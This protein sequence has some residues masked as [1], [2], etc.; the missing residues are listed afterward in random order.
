MNRLWSDSAVIV[1]L[2]CVLLTI[3][4]YSRRY[5]RSVADFLAARRLGGRYLLAVASGFGGGVSLVAMWEMTYASGFPPQ[6]WQMM[7]LPVGLFIGLSGFIV[8]RFRQTRCLTLA[9][10]FEERYSTRFRYFAGALCWLSGVLNYGIFPAVT[11]RFIMVCLQLPEEFS[12]FGVAIGTYPAVMIAYLSVALYI[13]CAGGR[14]V[15]C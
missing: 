11:A 9:Q 7:T 13:A 1:V 12:L 2:V 10:F 14:S 15:S 3:T 6:W 5:V 8:Y 4:L